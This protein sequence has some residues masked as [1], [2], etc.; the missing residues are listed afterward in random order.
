[1]LYVQFC[2]LDYAYYRAKA[3]V[4]LCGVFRAAKLAKQSGEPPYGYTKPFCST[5]QT[6]TSNGSLSGFD[7]GEAGPPRGLFRSQR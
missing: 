3:S 4:A 2:F 1:V 5:L 6:I 7:R